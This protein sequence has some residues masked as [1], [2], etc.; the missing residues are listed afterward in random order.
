[1]IGCPVETNRY[2]AAISATAKTGGTM[3]AVHCLAETTLTLRRCREIIES[4][5]PGGFLA[6]MG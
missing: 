2:S 5:W 4:I 6:A 3:R 1:M